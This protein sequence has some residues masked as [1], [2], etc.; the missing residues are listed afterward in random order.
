M[1]VRT[2]AKR[3]AIVRT[4]AAVFA[5]AGF[6]GASMADIAARVGGSKATLYGYFASK[7]ELFLA[8]ANLESHKHLHAAMLELN[9][10]H[11]DVRAEL[12]RFGEKLL[13]FLLDPQTLA[14]LRMVVAESGRSSIGRS[15]Y[16]QGPERGLRVMSQYFKD[17]IE[18]RRL[19]SA[20]DPSIMAM[21]FLGLLECELVPRYIYG[22]HTEAPRAATIRQA[23]AR[24]V[25]VFMDAYE[26]APS[27]RAAVAIAK[28]RRS[29]PKA[30]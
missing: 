3:E 19:R 18:R 1:R 24:A 15:F 8:V 4:A 23:A 21:Q 13:N 5:E 14:V 30:D 17:V 9:G 10:A 12:H 29:R 2:D 11:D 28:P 25:D 16:S 6:E 26:I 7:E 27:H 20:I 22:V